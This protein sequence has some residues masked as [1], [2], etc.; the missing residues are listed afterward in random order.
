[1]KKLDPSLRWGDGSMAGVTG[2]WLE[3][4]DYGWGDG[5]VAGVESIP[6]K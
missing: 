5:V 2:L 4:R 6:L 3:C 1:M